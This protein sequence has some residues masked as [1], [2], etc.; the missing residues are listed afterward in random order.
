MGHFIL[1]A[2]GGM[3]GIPR[4]T[5]PSK[6][7]GW[8]SLVAVEVVKALK[9]VLASVPTNPILKLTTTP[10]YFGYRRTLGI[11]KKNQIT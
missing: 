4:T 11:A 6:S 3:D 2:N 1:F 10:F 5:T 8:L 7:S 9:S